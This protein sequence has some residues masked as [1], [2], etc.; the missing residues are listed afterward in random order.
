MVRKSALIM[1]K[2]EVVSP[3]STRVLK[4]GWVPWH[5]QGCFTLRLY[6]F[7]TSEGLGFSNTDY[8]PTKKEIR[9]PCVFRVT[10]LSPKP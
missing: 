9:G 4:I 1:K 10:D 7:F 5:F 6:R 3:S 2:E 8:C